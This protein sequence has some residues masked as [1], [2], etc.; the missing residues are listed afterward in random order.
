[1]PRVDRCKQRVD[2]IKSSQKLSFKDIDE[3]IRLTF[4][5]ANYLQKQAL[6]RKL[7]ISL[8]KYGCPAHRI[9]HFLRLTATAIDINAAFVYMPDV[10]LLSFYDSAAHAT[11]TFFLGQTQGFDMSRLIE[12]YRLERLIT[13]GQTTVDDAIEYLERIKA[14]PLYFPEWVRSLSYAFAAFASSI[15]FFGGG[16][17]EAGMAAGLGLWLAIYEIFSSKLPG[18]GPLFDITVSIIIGFIATAVSYANIC[19]T[20][21]AFAAVIVLL[22]GWPMAMS[23]MELASRSIIS[24]VIRLVYAFIYSFLLAYGLT[25]GQGLYRTFDTKVQLYNPDTCPKTLSNWWYFL[26]VPWFCASI[27]IHSICSVS[28]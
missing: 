8:M 2:S 13:L 22:P 6:M 11:E 19:Y 16:W 15:I 5:I 7:A 28:F 3:R 17:K 24:G 20:P 25:T 21:T 10:I 27:A 26:F 23:I 12:V 9:Q 18:M 1:M 4:E 14:L